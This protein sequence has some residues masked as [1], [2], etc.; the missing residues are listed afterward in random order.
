MIDLKAVFRR[1]KSKKKL[2]FFSTDPKVSGRIDVLFGLPMTALWLLRCH[3]IGK[4]VGTSEIVSYAV[5]AIIVFGGLY[6]LFIRKGAVERNVTLGDVWHKAYLRL[7]RWFVPVGFVAVVVGYSAL[8][9]VLTLFFDDDEATFSGSVSH[10]V[11]AL[12]WLLICMLY[13]VVRRYVDFRE[14]Y[15]S[16]VASREEVDWY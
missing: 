4:W 13:S 15:R 7:G 2:M 16:P 9:A 14:Y 6:N 10:I 1:K 11:T 3:E 12:G 5:L 8:V